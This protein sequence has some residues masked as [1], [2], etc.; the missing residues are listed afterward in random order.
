M[1][2]F[3]GLFECGGRGLSDTRLRPL[4]RSLR[5][6]FC[7]PFFS[8]C[9]YLCTFLMWMMALV[10]SIFF[11]TCIVS[12]ASLLCFALFK[13]TYVVGGIYFFHAY[14]VNSRI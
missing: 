14:G 4:L 6:F 5:F 9:L 13:T 3:S 10:I 8:L 1:R 11:E 7:L 12:T 2:R